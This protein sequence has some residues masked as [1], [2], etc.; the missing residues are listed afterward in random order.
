MFTSA[1]PGVPPEQHRAGRDRLIQAGPGFWILQEYREAFTTLGLD[2]LDAVFA[3]DQGQDLAK[4]TIGR[5]RR[6][7]ELEIRRLGSDVPTRLFLK[8]YDHPP[9]LEQIRNWLAHHR[10][11]SFGLIERN[12]ARRL[13]AAGINAPRAVACGEQWGPLFEHRSFLAT[14]EVPD[15]DALERRLPQCF[16]DPCTSG[17]RQQRR[18]F[19]AALAHFTHR[20]HQTGYRHRDLYLSHVFCSRTGEFCLIDLARASRPFLK[21]RY[22]IKDIA[23]LHFSA[24]ADVFS[25]TD[26]L[27]FLLAYLGRRKLQQGDRVFVRKIV[28]KARRMARHNR[29]HHIPVPFQERAAGT[30]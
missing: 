11:G 18:D 8:R 28:S 19:I 16:E 27:R 26:R 22:Q 21:R 24:P 9:L 3:S 14:E 12:T 30:G 20:F 10:R 25:R 1:S 6:R 13:A 2:S 29:K 4:P 23:Q 7:L 5:F 15:S 17:K